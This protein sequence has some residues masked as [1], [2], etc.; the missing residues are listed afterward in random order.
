MTFFWS[1]IGYYDKS[2]S[3]T[4]NFTQADITLF[5]R[6]DREE[7]KI[8]N[9]QLGNIMLL[10]GVADDIERRMSKIKNNTTNIY[11]C[12]IHSEPMVLREKRNNVQGLLDQYFLGC[13]RWKP[14]IKGCNQ[15][16]KIKSPAQL[17]SILE[18]FYGRGIL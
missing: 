12:P 5:T 13:P 18:A 7:F 8:T 11:L 2:C 15:I 16:V 9:Q 4:E 17:T 6:I 3:N 14:E 10:P 1:C